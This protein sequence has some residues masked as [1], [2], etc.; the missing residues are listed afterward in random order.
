[1]EEEKKYGD[2]LEAQQD[3]LTVRSAERDGQTN[4]VYDS[5]YNQKLR[6]VQARSDD[7][8]LNMR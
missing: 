4:I 7:N 2:P 3:P 5:L 1:M 8:K 6:E